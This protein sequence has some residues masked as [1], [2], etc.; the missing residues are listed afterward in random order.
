MWFK[1]RCI[2]LSCCLRNV[3]TP[4]KLDWSRG[5]NRE[6]NYTLELST[7]R[8]PYY[9]PEDWLVFNTLLEQYVTAA[10][11]LSKVPGRCYISLL[12]KGTVNMNVH[13]LSTMKLTRHVGRM[14]TGCYSM[15]GNFCPLPSSLPLQ[16]RWHWTS[17]ILRSMM[18]SLPGEQH[19]PT[20]RVPS[21][22]RD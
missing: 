10:L 21:H 7:E 16:T 20:A 2:I 22:F 5:N 8:R 14:D 13:R 4:L 9:R 12:A 18:E 15:I 19:V 1:W 17:E 3:V 11:I 6:L